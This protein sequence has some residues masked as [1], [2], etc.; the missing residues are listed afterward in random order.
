[1]SLWKTPASVI[2][3]NKNKGYIILPCGFIKNGPGI[4]IEPAIKKELNATVEEISEAISE[5]LKVSKTAE[6]INN[7][8]VDREVLKRAT[9]LKSDTQ[10]YK[11]YECLECEENGKELVFTDY[12]DF[13]KSIPIND[14]KKAGNIVNEWIR[15]VINGEFR[16][17]GEDVTLEFETNFENKVTYLRPSDEFDDLGD[18]GTDAY[19]IYSYGENQDTTFAFLIE[20]E[21]SFKELTEQEIKSTWER[22]YGKLD[23]FS[24]IK[25]K[26]SKG[27]LR[28]TGKNKNTLVVSE[29]YEDGEVTMEVTYKIDR[30]NLEKETEY[31]LIKEFEK[32][33][34]SIRIEPIE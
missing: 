17:T 7:K 34:N 22:W 23:E 10:I 31:Y 18:G 13:N 4:I 6:E 2:C 26:N 1:M 32:V 25:P 3:Y 9:G 12:R 27:K 11:Q 30:N 19:Q 20:A 16:E 33:M 15:T 14:V 8:E 21:M 28:S 5:C 24:L 29:F